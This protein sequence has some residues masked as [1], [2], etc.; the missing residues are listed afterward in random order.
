MTRL[1]QISD[2]HFGAESPGLPDALLESL[3]ALKPDAVIASGDFTQ[4]G[5]RREFDAARDFFSAIDAPVIAAPGNHDTPYLNLAARVAAPWARFENGSAR[6]SRPAGV[7]RW[8][9]WNPF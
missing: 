4:Y 7:L 2:L 9:R 6:A 8:R 1:A 5:R 3:A